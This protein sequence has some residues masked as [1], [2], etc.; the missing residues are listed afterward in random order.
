M[1]NSPTLTPEE[2]NLLEKLV[3]ETPGTTLVT[4]AGG[5][6]ISFQWGSSFSGIMHPRAFLQLFEE[7]DE[8][9][10]AIDILK[11]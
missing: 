3:A 6:H 2:W 8:S 10:P 9:S 5:S 11:T 7:E 1:N 4:E